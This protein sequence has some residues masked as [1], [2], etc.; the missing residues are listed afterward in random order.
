MSIAT[1]VTSVGS[2]S[3]PAWVHDLLR[4]ASEIFSGILTTNSLRLVAIIG[5]YLLLRPHLFRLV[6]GHQ[7]SQLSQHLQGVHEPN[8]SLNAGSQGSE[9]EEEGH[10][11]VGG[12]RAR[13]IH[14]MRSRKAWQPKSGTEV[15]R[16]NAGRG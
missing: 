13:G 7:A 6:S 11:A 8:T 4:P 2:P 12:R 9:D 15:T 10:E 5:G 14:D 1:I 16:M 3:L